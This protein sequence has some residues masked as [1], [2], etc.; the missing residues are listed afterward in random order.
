MGKAS[1]RSLSFEQILTGEG[2]SHVD[3]WGENVLGRG[4]S[5]CEG[6][7]VRVAWNGPVCGKA[8]MSVWLEEGRKH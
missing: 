3:I 1:L 2:E 6:L 7:K 8:G 5:Q 4:N